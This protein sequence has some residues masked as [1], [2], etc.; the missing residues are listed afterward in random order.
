MMDLKCD[1]AVVDVVS[2]LGT[3]QNVS[4]HITK[5]H[6][7]AEGI[8]RRY[9]GRNKH[10]QEISLHDELVTQSIEDL[11]ENGEDA[12]SL[13]VETFEYAKRENEYLFV[14]FYASW[15]SHCRQ[16]A[17]TWEVLAE[18]MTDIAE[19][20]VADHEG[21]HEYSDED[22]AHAKKVELPVM[23]AK[24]DCVIHK[25]LCMRQGLLAYPT[26]RLFV[27]GERWEAGDYR[28]HRTVVDMADWLQQVEDKH[29][30]ELGDEAKKNVILA[31]ER[32][33]DMSFCVCFICVTR[34]FKLT[35]SIIYSHGHRQ[36]ICIINHR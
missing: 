31:H 32:T 36:H 10:Q 35:L 1:F 16:L 2:S 18:V 27:D 34:R 8:R 14:D 15:C 11:H 20:L 3:D 7:D 23:I 28:G 22:L 30:E 33:C 26:L 6:V 9:Q 21:R 12:I 25:E 19:K 24:V 5:W 13:D 29:K 4:A 17:P